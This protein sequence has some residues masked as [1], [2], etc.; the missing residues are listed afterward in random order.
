MLLQP[1]LHQRDLRP[2]EIVRQH[3][4]WNSAAAF[5]KGSAQARFDLLRA[6]VMGSP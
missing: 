5:G 3:V 1:P 4:E 6:P 2:R